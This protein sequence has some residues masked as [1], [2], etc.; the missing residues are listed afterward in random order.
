[1]TDSIAI[2]SN[3]LFYPEDKYGNKLEYLEVGYLTTEDEMMLCTPNLFHR[4]EVLYRLL[5]RKVEPYNDLKIDD[6][7]V[8]DKDVILLWLRENS[9]GN[10]IDYIDNKGKRFLFNT[11]DIKIKSIKT[12][13]DKN[14]LIKIDISNYNLTLEIKLLTVLDER[15]YKTKNNMINFYCA[16]IY[17]INGEVWSMD[18]KKSWLLSR[19][20]SLGREIKRRIDDSVFGVDK[21]TIYNYDGKNYNTTVSMDE[22]FFGLSPENLDKNLK[23]LNESIF[24]LCNEGQ[25]YTN[26]DV[27]EMP[28][29]IRI[30]HVNKLADKIKKHNNEMQTASRSKK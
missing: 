11:H 17:A 4:G 29:H 3:G 28:S 9:L 7:Y 16:S 12:I 2:P 26:K 30:Y 5:E 15:V 14:G 27:M 19:N 10:I 13:P 25:G 18:K 1:M 6:L 22:L 23:S 20:I 8:G 24:F 21:K